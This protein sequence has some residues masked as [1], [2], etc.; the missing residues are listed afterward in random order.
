MSE[1][2]FGSITYT[3]ALSIK[4]TGFGSPISSSNTGRETGFGSPF[5]PSLNAL[6][7]QGE[8]VKIGDDGGVKLY[9]YGDWKNQFTLP[10][11]A[12]LGAF[13]VSFINQSTNKKTLALGGRAGNKNECFT[14]LEQ[15]YIEAYVPPLTRGT[16]DL[17][18]E[19]DA[20][21][22]LINSAFQVIPRNKVKETYE[23]RKLLPSFYKAG[24]REIHQDSIVENPTYKALEGLTRSIGQQIA[25]V[26]GRLSTVLTASYN[27]NDTAL[28]VETT[29]GFQDTGKLK[30]NGYTLSYTGKTN[31]TF[32]GV[33]FVYENTL[34]I[35][36][37]GVIVQ[38]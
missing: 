10:A 21:N 7:I 15:T 5:D 28:N 19:W 29:L 13:T 16:Y 12:Y 14:N 20:S 11:P 33:S 32:T 37:G 9:I 22:A 38:C 17:K 36:K 3:P 24:K 4:D 25:F 8:A 30:V 34:K 26:S 35:N 2:G 27:L 6:A 31:N 1:T 18:V 23:L